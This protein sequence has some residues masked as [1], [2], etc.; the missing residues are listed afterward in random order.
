MTTVLQETNT[1]T[2]VDGGQ[3]DILTVATYWKMIDTNWICGNSTILIKGKIKQKCHH[4]LNKNCFVH[5]IKEIITF[6]HWIVFF[7]VSHYT[8]KTSFLVSSYCGGISFV[9]RNKPVLLSQ[10]LQSWNQGLVTIT[11]KNAGTKEPEETI[12]LAQETREWKKKVFFANLKKTFFSYQLEL[13]HIF[14][15]PQI[16]GDIWP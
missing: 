15:P 13:R 7:L 4:I 9:N 14:L 11:R 12:N 6:M 3:S 2:P 1:A 16:F 10:L 8:I 5:A